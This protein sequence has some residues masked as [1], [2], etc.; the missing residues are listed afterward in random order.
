[1]NSIFDARRCE[2]GEGALW[3]PERGQFFWFDIIGK[4]LL[5]RAR[6]QALEWRFDE[7]VSAA[8]WISGTELLIASETGLFVL[9]LETDRRQAI[10]TL[11]AQPHLR[12]ND[13]RADPWGG[14]WIGTMG[15]AGEDKAGAIWRYH[16]GDFRRLYPGIT[17]TNAICFDA[18]RSRAYFADTRRKTVWKVR[19]DSQGW[20]AADPEIYRDFTRDGVSPDGAVIDDAGNFWNAQWGAGRVAGYDLKGQEIAVERFGATR[21]SCPAFGGA[22]LDFLFVT[23]AQQGMSPDEREAEPLAGMTFGRRLGFKGVPEPRVILG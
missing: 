11:P 17:V 21:T 12:S 7:H 5:S 18:Q 3:H 23:T 19:L 15:K 8:G 1:M 13:G 4:R 22:D 20:P 14:F 2:L 16:R 9:D 6:E 10:V